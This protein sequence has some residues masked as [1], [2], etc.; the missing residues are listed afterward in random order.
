MPGMWLCIWP[1]SA[2]MAK[3]MS[4]PNNTGWLRA[5]ELQ[6][7]TCIL[8]LHEMFWALS[9]ESMRKWHSALP[10]AT[11]PGNRPQQL[12]IPKK[13]QQQLLTWEKRTTETKQRNSAFSTRISYWLLAVRPCKVQNDSKR[14]N[15]LM[16][17]PESFA[18]KCGWQGPLCLR[19][20]D[21]QGG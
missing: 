18:R 16:K 17:L 13:W 4:A 11:V 21:Q 6:S 3:S 5:S 12:S 2:T 7:A 20:C 15:L 9:R 10:N 14:W 19:G 1:G 8:F